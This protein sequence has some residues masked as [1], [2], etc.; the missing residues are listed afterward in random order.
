MPN[1]KRSEEQQN[2]DISPNIIEAV[3]TKRKME[4][5]RHQNELELIFREQNKL[6][7]IHDK[8]QSVF[9]KQ[10]N[11]KR[12]EWWKKDKRIRKSLKKRLDIH[13]KNAEINLSRIDMSDEEEEEQKEANADVINIENHLIILDHDQSKTD[14]LIMSGEIQSRKSSSAAMPEA[15]LPLSKTPLPAL[16]SILKKTGN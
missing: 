12:N 2:Y 13:L 16:K 3:V 1:K 6:M 9:L 5:S 8:N 10:T 15:F 4:L 11:M 14:S 7:T